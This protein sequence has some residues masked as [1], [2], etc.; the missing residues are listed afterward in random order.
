MKS[1]S[2]LSNK[3]FGK[4]LGDRYGRRNKKGL[5]QVGRGGEDCEF[6]W[7]QIETMG[8]GRDFDDVTLDDD[9]FGNK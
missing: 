3:L 9:E 2:H 5:F 1:Q 4:R 7:E 6:D 8:R